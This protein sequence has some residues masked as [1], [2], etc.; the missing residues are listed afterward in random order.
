MLSTMESIL[1]Y[2]EDGNDGEQNKN[3]AVQL[4]I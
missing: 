2:P 1:S 3:E 4:F